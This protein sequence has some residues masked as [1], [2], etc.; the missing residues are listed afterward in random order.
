MACQKSVDESTKRI[1][2]AVRVERLKLTGD[3]EAGFDLLSAQADAHLRTEIDLLND[4]PNRVVRE[5]LEQQAKI[6]SRSQVVRSPEALMPLA[7]RSGNQHFTGRADKLEELESAFLSAI[8]DEPML[9]VLHGTG[10]VGKSQ[11]AL[12]YAV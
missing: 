8:P 1:L 5:F 11:I 3:F 2:D 10:G 9:V 12:E 4:L 6:L 7:G